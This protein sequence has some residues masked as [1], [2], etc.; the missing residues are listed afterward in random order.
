MV[1]THFA[2]NTNDV[3]FDEE[4]LA[5]NVGGSY[6]VAVQNTDSIRT[7]Y[8]FDTPQQALHFADCMDSKDI[9]HE[10]NDQDDWY[11]YDFDRKCFVYP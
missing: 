4:P 1:V 9:Y 8:R 2:D 11:E 3:I 7:Y 5:D 10:V 6:I